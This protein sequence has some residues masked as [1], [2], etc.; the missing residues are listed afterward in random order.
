[1]PK[2][3]VAWPAIPKEV[4]VVANVVFENNCCVLAV[5]PIPPVP[6]NFGALLAASKFPH[7]DIL[8]SYLSDLIVYL[9]LSTT[10]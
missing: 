10:Q 9:Y 8:F 1:M 2:T 4:L 3:P 5:K 7:K 6:A